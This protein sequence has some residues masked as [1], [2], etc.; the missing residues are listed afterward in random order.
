MSGSLSAGGKAGCA[1]AGLHHRA[2]AQQ[3][4]RVSLPRRV[5]LSVCGVCG[6]M[7][8]SLQASH[9][10]ADLQRLGLVMT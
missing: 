10:G 8:V 2:Q 5:F 3:R 1:A 4:D 7:G 9:A 6:G